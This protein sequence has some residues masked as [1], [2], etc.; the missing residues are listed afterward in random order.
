MLLGV[1]LTAYA[2]EQQKAGTKIAGEEIGA[3]LRRFLTTENNLNTVEKG[4][5]TP[6]LAVSDMIYDHDKYEY[7]NDEYHVY[8]VRADNFVL[9]GNTSPDTKLIL[10][11]IHDYGFFESFKVQVGEDE[12]KRR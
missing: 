8:A 7:F 1:N 12:T 5:A 4:K 3:E 9:T 10:S 11:P 2:A 6:I